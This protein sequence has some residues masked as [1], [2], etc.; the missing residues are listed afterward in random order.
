M[1]DERD[2]EAAHPHGAGAWRESWAFEFATA[3]DVGVS[4]RLTLV[5]ERQVSWFWVAIIRPGHGPLVV[6]DHEAPLPR[7]GL[8]LRS[9]GLWAELVCEEP[10]E[11]WG[12]G[13]EAFGVELDDPI[14][15][16]HGERGHRL[17][18]GFDLEWEV[19]P[20]ALASPPTALT[21]VEQCG[22]GSGELLI[23][24]ERLDISGPATRS[25]AW[26]NVEGIA[27]WHRAAFQ[28]DDRLAASWWRSETS[29]GACIARLG[30]PAEQLDHA[31]CETH[32]DARGLPV[33]ARAVLGHEMEIDVDVVGLA[34]VEFDAW[35]GERARLVR[36]LCHFDTHEG[37][38]L[39]W[40][41][42]LQSV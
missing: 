19:A 39:G 41:E 23:G 14:D 22:I 4:V 8:E 18:V 24:D 20:P 27:E 7:V 40:S 11:F 35:N 12:L 15:A 1:T 30:E 21:R 29:T 25:H 3:D 42:W 33:A 36:A 28:I 9:D 13:L 16:F 2:S 37:V 10:L 6:H 32:L 34:P 5:P 26:G 31:L 38:G 17:P